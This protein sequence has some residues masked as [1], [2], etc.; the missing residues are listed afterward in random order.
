MAIYKLELNI[1]L[2]SRMDDGRF[3]IHEIK[4]LQELFPFEQATL[5]EDFEDFELD[6]INDMG[7][8]KNK[9]H[10]YLDTQA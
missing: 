2:I 8:L 3:L 5:H 1:L 10:Y 6:V 9:A 4:N 7:L